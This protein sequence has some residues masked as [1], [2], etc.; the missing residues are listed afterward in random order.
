[1][2]TAACLM[3]GEGSSAA[4]R[5]DAKWTELSLEF[6]VNEFRRPIELRLELRAR[7]GKA[8][9]RRSSLLLYKL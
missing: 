6:D 3:A 2:A 8:W 4:R 9:L 7:D 5:G 1:M